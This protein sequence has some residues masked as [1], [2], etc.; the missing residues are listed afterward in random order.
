MPVSAPSSEYSG[1]L[2]HSERESVKEPKKDP[3][4][5]DVSAQNTSSKLGGTLADRAEKLYKQ[6]ATLRT[7]A[8]NA[9]INPMRA[10]CSLLTF[11]AGATSLLSGDI[12]NGL[13][14]TTI[15]AKEVWNQCRGE[16]S[17]SLQRLLND[18]NAD[19]G[20]IQTLEE[21]NRDSFNTVKGN[22]GLIDQ[23]VSTLQSQLDAIKGI[24]AQGSKVIKEKKEESLSLNAQSLAAYQKAAALFKN[25]QSKLE[26][27]SGYYA[28]CGKL[29]GQIEKIAKAEDPNINLQEKI[30]NLVETARSASENSKSG[31]TLLDASAVNLNEAL[32][33][34]KKANSLKDQATAASY[35]A[36]QMAEDASHAIAEKVV[37]TK[38]CNEKIKATQKEMEKIQKRSDQIMGLI[39][40]LKRDVVDAKQE[41]EKKFGLSEVVVGV[42]VAAAMGPSLGLV[43]GAA[44]GVSALY[45]FRNSSTLAGTASKMYNWAVGVSEPESKPMGPNEL[46]SVEFNKTSSGYWGYFVQ[47]RPSVTVGTLKVNLGDTQMEIPFNLNERDKIP[48]ENLL[49]LF[50]VMN[51]K[52]M[53]GTLDPKRCL[54]ILD[55]LE[56]VSMD[57]KDLHPVEMGLIER[58]SPTYAIVTLLR[59]ACEKIA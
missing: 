49:D 15:G 56:T 18:I 37:Y 40:E 31:K 36:I 30:D 28:E 34:L 39:E 9:S 21:A 26:Q 7:F 45:A 41:A 10:G 47:Q 19:A 24:N 12:V 6:T 29:F 33:E 58:R 13:I 52:V 4:I 35:A 55:R 27:S 57:R 8:Q 11:Y 44:T 17:S 1:L 16:S 5:G 25:T 14:V 38:E 48:K 50:K 2:R 32:E 20:M 53:A 59:E 51:K 54:A 3:F 23:G 43:Y 22:L 46:I 42:G